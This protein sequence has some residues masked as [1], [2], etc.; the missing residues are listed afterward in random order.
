MLDTGSPCPKCGVGTIVLVSKYHRAPNKPY[1]TADL[2]GPIPRAQTLYRC[3]TGCS[4]T[5]KD[6]PRSTKEKPM[7]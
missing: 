3:S 7:R 4:W 2:A 5:V 1:S 6:H